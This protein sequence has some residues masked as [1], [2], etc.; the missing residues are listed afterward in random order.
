VAETE[1]DGTVI[2]NAKDILG[3][4]INYSNKAIK[5]DTDTQSVKS[6]ITN[7]YANKVKKYNPT[8]KS[9]T[10]SAVKTGDYFEFG[11]WTALAILG[12]AGIA[13]FFVARKR[14]NSNN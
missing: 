14:K 5:I 11:A 1:K 3:C 13:A 12:F 7:Q 2:T 9:T 6:T 4:K 8:P 10:S